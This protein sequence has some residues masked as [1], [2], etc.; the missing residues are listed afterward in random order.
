MPQCAYITAASP[1]IGGEYHALCGVE[2]VT[3]LNVFP[4]RERP[5]EFRA[6]DPRGPVR[7][8]WFSQTIGPNRGLE[9]IV[10]A[11]ALLRS[12]RVEL[13]LRGRWQAGYEAELRGLAAQCGVPPGILV[14]HPPASPEDMVRA[15]AEYDVG[16]ALEPPVTANSDILLSN[17]IFTYVLAG[18]AIVATRTKAQSWLASQFDESAM[19]CDANRPESLAAALRSWL[20]GSRDVEKARR[21][22]WRLGESRFNWDREKATFLRVV[23]GALDAG[24]S[25]GLAAARAAGEPASA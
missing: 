17:K 20:D 6:R 19:L 16:L 11:L 22:A 10:Q 8:Y 15:A 2:P 14:S 18:N 9:D 25:R 3:V 23:Q 24:V 12:Y 21:T 5:S 1:G 7:L 4:L 13:H